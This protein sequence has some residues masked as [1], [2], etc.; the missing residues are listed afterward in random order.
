MR[1]IL[2]GMGGDNAPGEIVKGAVEASKL[3]EDEIIIVGDGD[4]IEFQLKKYK[5][6]DEKISVKHASEVIENDD[7]P[8]RAVR[9]KKDSSMVVGLN[10]VKSGEGDLFISAGNTGALMAGALF[11]LGR[12]QGIDRPAIASI[13]PILGTKKPSLLVDAGANSECKPSNLLEFAM[14]GSIYMEKVLGREN[15]KIGLVNLGVEETK[16]STLTKAAFGLLEKS[17]LNFSGN[18]EAREVPLGG[19][20][21]VVCDGF[22][23]N[24]ILKLTEGLAINIVNLLKKKFTENARAKMG[25]VLLSKKLRS[26]KEEFDYTEYGGAPI[27]GVKGPVVKMHGSSNANA[28]KNSILKAIPFAEENVVGIISESVFEIEEVLIEEE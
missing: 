12:I 20:D 7:A 9:R 21:V 14:M 11:N 19:A 27:L 6:S 13:Y 22:V 10:M 17:H 4:K 28:V 25:A 26:L 3:I 2:D 15:P 23:G 8:V 1:I 18:I 5:Y 16:G 24:V